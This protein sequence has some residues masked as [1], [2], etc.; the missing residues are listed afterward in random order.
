MSNR[1]EWQG[2]TWLSD[3]KRT[4]KLH[5]RILIFIWRGNQW[6]FLCVRAWN[7][8]N[9]WFTGIHS[10][11]NLYSELQ[12]VR[13]EAD[14]PVWGMWSVKQNNEDPKESRG[15]S[16]DRNSSGGRTGNNSSV[17]WVSHDKA[18]FNLISAAWRKAVNTE[19]GAILSVPGR[20]AVY[21]RKPTSMYKP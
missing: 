16:G 1:R 10:W 6:N 13:P 11:D 17:S 4:W 3:H 19:S 9:S 5:Y 18:K 15:S 21:T 7:G 20:A 2:F 14:E 8:Q 12:G